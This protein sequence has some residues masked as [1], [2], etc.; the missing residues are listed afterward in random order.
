MTVDGFEWSAVESRASVWN[1]EH[2]A[3][4]LF[5]SGGAHAATTYSAVGID[6]CEPPQPKFESG[7]HFQSFSRAAQFNITVSVGL[8]V[9]V[10]RLNRKR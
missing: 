1:R 9:P 6:G 5:S 2:A 4:P 8:A 10:G 3:R 7:T